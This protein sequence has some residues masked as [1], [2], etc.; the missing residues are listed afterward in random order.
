MEDFPEYILTAHSYTKFKNAILDQYP[1]VTGDFI[2][3]IR[4]MDQL[5]GE[6]QHVEITT[7]QDLSNYHL[8]FLAIT[9]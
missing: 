8:Q 4:D 7:M 2:Y 6:R 1:D 3:F 5:I 9:Q